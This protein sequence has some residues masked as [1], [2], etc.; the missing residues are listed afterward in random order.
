MCRRSSATSTCRCSSA[1]D[2][3]SIVD[4]VLLDPNGE[5]ADVVSNLTPNDS[6]TAVNIGRN[7]EALDANPCRSLAP[8][9]SGAEPGQRNGNLRTVHGR[10]QF[11]GVGTAGSGPAE[12]RWHT[13]PP[14]FRER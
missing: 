13:C 14:A 7:V 6:G 1:N 9:G 2:P 8:G 4:M 3:N 11:N 10:V 12:V 5:L